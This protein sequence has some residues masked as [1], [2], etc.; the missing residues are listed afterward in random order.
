VPVFKN[1][2]ME[3]G[4]EVYFTNSLRLYLDTRSDNMSL[5]SS[6]GEGYIEG[7]VEEISLSPGSIRFGTSS[8]E[9]SGGLPDQT[10][11][12]SSYTLRAKVRLSLIR[13]SD[14]KKLWS[15]SFSQSRSISSGT[16]TDIR[17]NSNI[18]IRE[19]NKREG[20]KELSSTMMKFAIDSMLEDF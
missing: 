14:S 5:V 2:T 3:S 1:N 7:I 10:L 6:D 9:A 20:L 11:L 8:T 13:R 17:K 15:K 16:Y 4:A 12:A 18:F 19:A